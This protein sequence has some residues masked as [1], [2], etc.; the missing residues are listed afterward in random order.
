MQWWQRKLLEIDLSVNYTINHYLIV[1]PNVV[2]RAG[3]LSPPHVA[4]SKTERNRTTSIKPMSSSTAPWIKQ[5]CCE[6]LG[7]LEHW[8]KSRGVH[9]PLRY[10]AALSSLAMSGLTFS[11]ADLLSCYSCN[12]LI[13]ACYASQPLCRSTIGGRL[14]CMCACRARIIQCA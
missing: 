6:H 7:L 14:R 3:Q 11:V 8:S 9:A 12:I 13:S 5:T 1:R 4:I 2:Q 10:G